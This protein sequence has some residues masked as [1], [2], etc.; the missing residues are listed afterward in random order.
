MKEQ[1]IHWYAALS[2]RWGWGC[3]GKLLA[4]W[5]LRSHVL[6]RPRAVRVP[7]SKHT[8]REAHRASTRAGNQ[9]TKAFPPMISQAPSIDKPHHVTWQRKTIS[10]AYVNFHRANEK[11]A[12][13]AESTDKWGAPW[14][15]ECHGRLVSVG[16]E[17]CSSESHPRHAQQHLCI[18]QGPSGK[19]QH[20]QIRTL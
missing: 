1:G 6:G 8:G 16:Q 17:R 14:D 3:Q 12:F 4:A 2:N 7:W 18:R 15:L 13:G 20:T 9:E 10:K 19:Q 5:P 11:A